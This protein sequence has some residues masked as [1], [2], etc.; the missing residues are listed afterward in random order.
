MLQIANCIRRLDKV[1]DYSYLYLH[2]FYDG[3]DILKLPFYICAVATKQDF[4]DILT[5]TLNNDILKEKN[6]GGSNE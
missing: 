3:C 2:E 5:L 1:F 6:L 4:V